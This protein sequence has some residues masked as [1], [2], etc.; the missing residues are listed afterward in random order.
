MTR[1]QMKAEKKVDYEHVLSKLSKAEVGDNIDLMIRPTCT[2]CDTHALIVE[3][4]SFIQKMSTVKEDIM[5]ALRHYEVGLTKTLIHYYFHHF[6]DEAISY[7]RCNLIEPE[8]FDNFRVSDTCS[9]L[10]HECGD[11][12]T[13]HVFP[14]DTHRADLP[15]HSTSADSFRRE[16][17]RDPASLEKVDT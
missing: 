6:D 17:K 4:N 9:T 14:Q 3:P 2:N 5:L 10:G 7:F 12:G 11:H 8:D 15:K 16:V 13:A 1:S